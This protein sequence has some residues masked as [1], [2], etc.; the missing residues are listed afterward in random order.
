M[1]TWKAEKEE[2]A[3]TVYGRKIKWIVANEVSTICVCWKKTDAEKIAKIL[4]SQG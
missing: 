4:N 2:Y 3:G 1:M